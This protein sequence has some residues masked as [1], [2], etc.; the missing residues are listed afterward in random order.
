MGRLAVGMDLT[1]IL[2]EVLDGYLDEIEWVLLSEFDVNGGCVGLI[3]PVQ[4][5]LGGVLLDR[6]P[7][8]AIV[9]H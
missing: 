4:R 9:Y 3:G 1:L 6:F 8:L 5:F 7:N 2:D